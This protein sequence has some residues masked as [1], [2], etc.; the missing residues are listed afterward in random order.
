MPTA[1]PP[2]SPP[3]QLAPGLR[4]AR[5]AARHQRLGPA[6]SLAGALTTA[7]LLVPTEL[8]LRTL[9]GNRRAYLPWLFHRGLARSL[10]IRIV[11]HGKPA[12][13]ARPGTQGVLYVANHVSWADIPVL[14]AH[15]RAAFVAK[16]E[17][18]GWGVVGWLATLART[19]YV[20]R[21]RRSTTA[22][23]RDSLSARLAH[24]ESLILF[25]EG[26][27]SDGSRVL[28]FKSALFAA[29]HGL[30]GLRVQPITIAY[31]RLNGMPV[32]RK[33]LPDLAWVGETELVPHAVAFMALGSIRAEILYH[34]LVIAADF[35]DRKALARHCETVIRAGYNKLMR[36]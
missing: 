2:A 16:A 27:N 28:P 5:D 3:P 36:G 22:H 4:R 11:T 26:T 34:P 12:G 31:T 30:E 9:S 15:I 35:P 7:S 10:G 25:P 6:K 14:G 19:A 21:D 13:T 33:Q 1:P 18:G 20:T 17:V 29:A 23:Q 24:G 32:T 8:L